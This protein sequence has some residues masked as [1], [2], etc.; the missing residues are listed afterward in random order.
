MSYILTFIG[1]CVVGVI[2]MSL[3][4]INRPFSDKEDF[5]TIHNLND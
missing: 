1:G 3:M 4:Q 5:G 2:I